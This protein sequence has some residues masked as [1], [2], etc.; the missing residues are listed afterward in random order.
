MTAPDLCFRHR[1]F[2]QAYVLDSNAR[3]AAVSAGYKPR[4]A[5]RQATR[6]LN[7]PQITAA[8]DNC[9]RDI[10]RRHCADA[11]SLMVKLEAIYRRA[12]DHGNL[13]AATQAVAQQARLAGIDGAAPPAASE[14]PLPKGP[15][16]RTLRPC[17]T[18]TTPPPSRF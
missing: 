5:A 14:N 12:L 6:L 17:P 7:L 13:T 18:E 2:V 8:L 3:R 4:H 9:R 16:P 10:A 1:A 15:A 11:D